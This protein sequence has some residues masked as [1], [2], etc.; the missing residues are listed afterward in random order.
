MSQVVDL[1]AIEQRAQQ[2]RREYTATGQLLARDWCDTALL[3]AGEI[4]ALREALAPFA[5]GQGIADADIRRA[6][7]VLQRVTDGEQP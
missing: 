4:R 7:A 6:A 3:L 5:R 1:R 2:K